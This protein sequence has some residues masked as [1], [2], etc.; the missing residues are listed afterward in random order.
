MSLEALAAGL[1]LGEWV[2]LLG[3]VPED[4]L[5]GLYRCSDVFAIASDVEVQSIPALQALATGLPVVAV[6]AAA[7]PELVNP[8]VNGFLAPPEDPQAL[9]EAIYQ[10]L[11]DPDRRRAMGQAS[12]GLVKNHAVEETFTQ[13]ENFYRRVCVKAPPLS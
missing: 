5:P 8:G 6:N 11:N 9:G 12:L 3:Y 10:V 13:Y 2:H 4:D 7:L 1:E